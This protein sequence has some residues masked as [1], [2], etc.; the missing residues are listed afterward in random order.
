MSPEPQTASP[1]EQPRGRQIAITLIVSITMLSGFFPGSGV[2]QTTMAV[3]AEVVS[4]V[5]QQVP[6][7]SV[8]PPVAEVPPADSCQ[9]LLH[10][11]HF[12]FGPGPKHDLANGRMDGG[13]CTLLM[14]IPSAV[15]CS[16]KLHIGTM[17]TGHDIHTSNG[18]VSEHT[19]FRAADINW[20][21]SQKVNR[22]NGCARETVHWLKGQTNRFQRIQ[23]GMP[24][25][26]LQVGNRQSPIHAFSDDDHSAH[27]H[28]GIRH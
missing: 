28:L 1:S 12:S 20:V 2:M 21:G 3:A 24:F 17:R 16:S 14:Q 8:T 15:P 11:Q 27:L 7:L 13:L 10:S 25:R 22:G 18:A 6:E 19:H 26:D 9:A 5:T 23:I 4:E